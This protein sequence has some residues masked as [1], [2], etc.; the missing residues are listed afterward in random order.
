MK[1]SIFACC[2]FALLGLA[3]AC[4][5]QIATNPNYDPISNTVN[6]QFVLNIAPASSEMQTKQSSEAVQKSNNFRG[7]GNASI[8]TFEVKQGAD[9]ADGKKIINLNNVTMQKPTSYID[10]STALVANSID[11]WGQGYDPTDPNS[12]PWSRRIVTID[13]PLNTNTLVFYGE[14]VTGTSRDLKN[15]YGQLEYRTDGLKD[16]DMTKIGCWAAPRLRDETDASTD[17][18]RIEDIMAAVY[19][20]LFKVERKFTSSYGSFDM[21]GVTVKFEDY[22]DA[23]DFTNKKTAKSPIPRLIND[24]KSLTGDDKVPEVQASLLEVT[25]AKAYYAFTHV[26]SGEY[27]AGSGKSI[28]RQ[29]SDFYVILYD[30]LQSDATQSLDDIAQVMCSDLTT[31]L[32]WFFKGVA[33]NS[34]VLTDWQPLRTEKGVVNALKE[35]LGITLDAPLDTKY[36]L[37]DFPLHFGLPIGA[38][39]MRQN[40]DGTFYYNSH[41]I[42]LPGMGGGNMSVHDYTYP[43]SLVYFG[44]SPVRI[45]N[46]NSLNVTD[47]QDGTGY[48][49]T[50]SNNWEDGTWNDNWLGE[51]SH[52]V[53]ATRG[54]AMAYNIQYANAMMATTVQYADSVV[55]GNRTGLADNNKVLNGEAE[56]NVFYPDLTNG[57]QLTGILIGGQPDTV[58]WNYLATQHASFNKMVY[59]KRINSANGTIDDDGGSTYF[60]DIP[61]DG[62]KSTVNYSV[63]FDNYNPAVAG[64]TVYVALEFRNNLGSDFWGNANMVRN[65]GAFYLLGKLELTADMKSGFPWSK[66]SKIMPPYDSDGK[67][68]TG[69]NYVRVFMQDFI[70]NV[71]FTIGKDALKYAYVTVPDLRS[72]SMSLGLSVDLEWKE[73]LSF[74]NVPLGYN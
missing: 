70:T 37:I 35:H 16:L 2:A 45:S 47:F 64:Q 13:L 15:D 19:N 72:S 12:K 40:S 8:L 31:Y 11:P 43:P 21:S 73:G 39:T 4:V 25:L 52:V 54:V 41:A 66:V 68:C 53:S 36:T 56:D 38:S 18:H 67:T 49:T 10:L 27:R 7:L 65:G 69:V 60:L 28:L 55:N 29:M 22:L 48:G 23:Y 44:N 34:R 71:N 57:L 9:L 61:S 46:A 1:K 3:T 14:A 74:D 62:K 59:D 51:F 33:S 17:Y 42:P 6:T 20:N 58:G 50:T 5:D 30:A 24:Q 26:N 32:S 63:V